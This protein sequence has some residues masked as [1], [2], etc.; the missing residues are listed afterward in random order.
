MKNKAEILIN[1]PIPISNKSI[2][3]IANYYNIVDKKKQIPINYFKPKRHS[4]NSK[5]AK[6]FSVFV[7]IY[8]YINFL[9]ILKQYKVV[10]LNPSMTKS[11]IYRDSL[12]F[13]LA[14]LLNKKVVVFWR[15]FNHNYFTSV[16]KEKYSKLLN[17]TLLKADHTIVL[18]K[19][20]YKELN[21][22][23]FN[24]SYSIATTILPEE[25][26]L[27][28]KRVF[29]KDKFTL[30]FLARLEKD[31]GIFEALEAYKI[32]KKQ[33]AYINFLIAG[34][35]CAMDIVKRK[36]EDEKIDDVTLLGHVSG[37]NKYKAYLEADTYFLPSYYEGMPNSVLEAMGMGLPVVT[38]NV[39]A[40]P[41]IVEN[42]KMGYIINDIK[43]VDKYV[44]AITNLIENKQLGKIS[45][46]NRNKAKTKFLDKI[47]VANLESILIDVM[48]NTKN[49]LKTIV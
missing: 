4:N 7:Y 19:N 43:N 13:L 38:S 10:V 39:G 32:L 5:V 25:L 2:G 6:L 22:I 40:L 41:D 45:D 46:Y 24:S 42:G 49:K 37:V 9:F 26:L 8:N 18:G 15:G 12:Y 31:K 16:V 17:K 20:I 21:S 23:G 47:V 36:I 48:D 1:V 44:E 11:C 27:K 3:G 35:G 28:E 29:K 14:K 30:L 34:S 33:F